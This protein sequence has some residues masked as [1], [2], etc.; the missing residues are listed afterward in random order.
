MSLKDVKTKKRRENRKEKKENKRD[1]LAASKVET[2][3]DNALM[4]LSGDVLCRHFTNKHNHDIYVLFERRLNINDAELRQMFVS[5][6]AEE[7]NKKGY[8]TYIKVSVKKKV[9]EQSLIKDAE[10]QKIV[11]ARYLKEKNRKF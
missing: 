9:S 10:L 6:D 8:V 11:V 2:S 7:Q 5:P 4:N 1:P 3:F